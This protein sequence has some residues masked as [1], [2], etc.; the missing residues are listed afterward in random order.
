[1]F[2]TTTGLIRAKPIIYHRN[3]KALNSLWI[4]LNSCSLTL[5]HGQTHVV[6][7]DTSFISLTTRTIKSHHLTFC[8]LLNS[9]Y[10][11]APQYFLNDLRNI[12]FQ[13]QIAFGSYLSF[14]LYSYAELN[15]IQINFAPSRWDLKGSKQFYN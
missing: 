10:S 15:F 8:L 7:Y 3:L 11:F 9:G 13:W 1:M 2:G 12:S 6:F 4:C 14:V 5:F